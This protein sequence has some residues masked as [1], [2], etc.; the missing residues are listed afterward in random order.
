MWTPA[1]LVS[2]SPTKTQNLRNSPYLFQR[3][4][5]Q[6]LKTIAT[7]PDG[8]EIQIWLSPSYEE[9]GFHWFGV[10]W[11]DHIGWM[12][13]VRERFED[14]FILGWAPPPEEEQ[15]ILKS[16]FESMVVDYLKSRLQ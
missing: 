5:Y 4:D 13:L 15:R 10:W 1:R 9:D 8:A 16:E 14:Q 11:G 2:I 3:E 12:A 7:V 6:E